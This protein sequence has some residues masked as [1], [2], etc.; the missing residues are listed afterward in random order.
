[1]KLLVVLD[2]QDHPGIIDMDIYPLKPSY[3]DNSIQPIFTYLFSSSP[4][5]IYAPKFIDLSVRLIIACS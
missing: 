3:L 2:M 4:Y 5:K 1:M